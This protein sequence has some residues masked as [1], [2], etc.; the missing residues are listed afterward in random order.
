LEAIL[1]QVLHAQVGELVQAQRYERTDDWQGYPP[2]TSR[3]NSPPASVPRP[4]TSPKCVRAAS[5]PS[6]LPAIS[7]P[8]K[9]SS[10]P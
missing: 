2:A 8:N 1:N 5:P 7:A 3:A 4:Y 6:S 9:P 10:S